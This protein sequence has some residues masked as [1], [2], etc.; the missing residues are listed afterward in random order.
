MELSG[1][2]MKGCCADCKKRIV[3]IVGR[4]YE[5]PFG[6]REVYCKNCYLNSFVEHYCLDHGVLL[7]RRNYK[8]HARCVH[9]IVFYGLVR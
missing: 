9:D 7:D 6:G 1:S 3:G 2:A 8:E 5:R 4:D